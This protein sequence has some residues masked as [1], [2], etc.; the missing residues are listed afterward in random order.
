MTPAY[1][2]QIALQDV[3]NSHVQADK[4]SDADVIGA[5]RVCIAIEEFN[6]AL[7]MTAVVNKLNKGE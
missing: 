4:L 6:L 3:I 2:L 1:S 5:L 7:R